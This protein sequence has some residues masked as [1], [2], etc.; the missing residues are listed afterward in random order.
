MYFLYPYEKEEKNRTP[1]LR[2]CKADSKESLSPIF[3]ASEQGL[4]TSV[5]K[6]VF[7][8]PRLKSQI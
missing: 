6:R 4:D 5:C 7:K 8:P 1:D 3:V 2:G